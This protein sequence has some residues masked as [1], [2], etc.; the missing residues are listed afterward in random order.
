MKKNTQGRAKNTGAGVNNQ[1]QPEGCESA[2]TAEG[3]AKI[4]GEAARTIIEATAAFLTPPEKEFIL[5]QP[6]GP[7]KPP[8]DIETARGL[9][10][11]EYEAAL[12]L[13]YEDTSTLDALY[14]CIAF[15]PGLG[16]ERRAV[17][18]L[19]EGIT[20]LVNL[21]NCHECHAD[22]EGRELK[23]AERRLAAMLSD[24]AGELPSPTLETVFRR[25]AQGHIWSLLE[26]CPDAAKLAGAVGGIV[27]AHQAFCRLKNY[28]G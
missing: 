28:Q 11:S 24:G 20:V 27:E 9:I 25:I 19:N 13:S 7:V 21:G 15:H 1:P 5:F 16:P 4:I 8:F 6:F 10:T 18:K 2:T 26:D 22:W 3:A 14:Q 23:E 12:K 17:R